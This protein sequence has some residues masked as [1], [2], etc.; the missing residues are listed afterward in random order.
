[1]A[2]SILLGLLLASIYGSLLS[3]AGVL[4]LQKESLPVWSPILVIVLG[5]GIDI[6]VVL[7]LL[8]YN[9][10][11]IFVILGLLGMQAIAVYNGWYLYKRINY[12]HQSIRLVLS[13]SIIVLLVL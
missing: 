6:S 11:F 7:I 12:S 1:M 3:Y 2:I 4:Q 13:L 9:W 8:S 10:A 5:L